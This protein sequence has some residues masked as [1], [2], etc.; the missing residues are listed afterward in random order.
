[1][2]EYS[3]DKIKQQ[4]NP[5]VYI[6]NMMAGGMRAK[7][8]IEDTIA[9]S[10]DD[11]AMKMAE[12]N[13]ALLRPGESLSEEDAKKSI[14]DNA[15]MLNL[16][17]SS[18][19]MG[20]IKML[21]SEIYPLIEKL[22]NEGNLSERSLHQLLNK[23][24]TPPDAGMSYDTSNIDKNLINDRIN[25]TTQLQDSILRNRAGLSDNASYEDLVNSIKKSAGVIDADIHS[26][27]VK[28]AIQRGARLKA[29]NPKMSVAQARQEAKKIVDKSPG[30]A[31]TSKYGNNVIYTPQNTDL[32]TLSHEV[33]HVL[34]SQSLPAFETTDHPEINV[35]PKDY[36]HNT[37][38]NA[39]GDPRT[40]DRIIHS[41][42]NPQGILSQEDLNAAVKNFR[43]KGEQSPDLV[44]A[45]TAISETGHFKAPYGPHYSDLSEITQMMKPD[46]NAN[47]VINN[48]FVESI[49]DDSSKFAAIRKLFSK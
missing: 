27:P 30:F 11:A 46:Y 48:K 32:G 34:E 19:A 18:P 37:V 21:P 35:Y 13:N 40:S 45:A 44:G 31:M 3:W 20:I 7:R 39:A 6:P 9:N 17:A 10:S 33:K 12:T 41:E 22:H 15:K 42:D 23:I 28:A 14:E 47:N 36:A 24:N 2:S 29:E 4:L 38:F 26:D 49:P 43:E 5:A 1:M 16:A 25:A 8:G